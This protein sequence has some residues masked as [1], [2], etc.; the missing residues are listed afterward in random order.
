[1]DPA[2][3][4]RLWKHLRPNVVPFV[5]MSEEQINALVDAL[6]DCLADV[7]GIPSDP[8][9]V[10]EGLPPIHH[11]EEVETSDTCK[12]CGVHTRRVRMLCFKCRRQSTVHLS[13]GPS[14]LDVCWQGSHSSLMDKTYW[15]DCA[16]ADRCSKKCSYALERSR[17]LASLAS[18]VGDGANVVIDDAAIDDW[19]LWNEEIVAE[20]K[21]AGLG[22]CIE[23]EVRM[24]A[25]QWL[26]FLDL[27]ICDAVGLPAEETLENVTDRLASMIAKSVAMTGPPFAEEMVTSI[28]QELR[29][30]TQVER[31]G[32]TLIDAGRLYTL[33]KVVSI[34]P[35]DHGVRLLIETGEAADAFNV[36]ELKALGSTPLQKMVTPPVNLSLIEWWRASAEGRA[37]L[38]FIRSLSSDLTNHTD[39]D[40]SPVGEIGTTNLLPSPPWVHVQARWRLKKDLKL[41]PRQTNSE[42]RVYRLCGL[43][44]QMLR[45]GDIPHATISSEMMRSLCTAHVVRSSQMIASA[46]RQ[47][48]PAQLVL[49]FKRTQEQLEQCGPL[50]EDY[51]RSAI[52]HLSRFSTE[53]VATVVGRCFDGV[54][55]QIVAR[56]HAR[57]PSIWRTRGYSDF[58]YHVLP[59]TLYR[60]AVSRKASPL[61]REPL[62]L[63]AMFGEQLMTIPAVREWSAFPVSDLDLCADDVHGK[64]AALALLQACEKERYLVRR[65]RVGTTMVW[66][67]CQTDL[68]MALQ[69]VGAFSS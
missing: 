48:E 64:E 60:F 14:L 4:G 43:L 39:K 7:L 16:D 42:E 26:H 27:C 20:F 2:T 34:G 6:A 30:V 51:M 58:M 45:A 69:A 40:Y 19:I 63:V 53:Q 12:V 56:I 37:F 38:T 13:G 46:N 41:V 33:E 15:Q 55:D 66:S 32:H 36:C 29:D 50:I 52:V 65:K 25:L 11:D 23:E 5:P 68:Q 10:K 24:V 3:R 28:I 8:Y 21:L 47:V 9:I 61:P 18:A 22:T 54:Y 35:S 31:M 49:A 59:P 1:M 57:L 44:V 62:D 67:L 17:Y